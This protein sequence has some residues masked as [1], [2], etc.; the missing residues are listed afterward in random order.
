M[1]LIGLGAGAVMTLGADTVMH[2]A[3]LDRTGDAGAIQ[4]S[5]FAL[6]AGIGVATLGTIAVATSNDGANPLLG[7]N[8][9]YGVAAVTLLATASVFVARFVPTPRCIGSHS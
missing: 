1:A 6:G 4:E 3:P 7:M 5:A 9:A 8:W 2:S